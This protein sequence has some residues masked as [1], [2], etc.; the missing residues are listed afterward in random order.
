MQQMGF[1]PVL[2][3]VAL[4]AIAF[5]HDA[6]AC[7]CVEP[8]PVM[9]SPAKR[10]PA[11]LNS[12]V[13]VGLPTHK[14]AKLELRKVGGAAVV[15]TRS[16]STL[17][18]LA[19]VTLTPVQPL[20]PRAHY[21]VASIE[22]SKSPSTLVFGSFKTGET[23]DVTAPTLA[24]L[25]AATAYRISNSVGSMCQTSDPWLEVA[26]VSATDPGRAD[27]PLLFGVWL[28]DAAG[29]VSTR[30]PPLALLARDEGD[31]LRIGNASLCQPM[32]FPFP[33]QANVVL[34][35]AALDEAGNA[36]A[37]QTLRVALGAARPPKRAG[38]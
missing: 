19:Q 13:V 23:R 15:T 10:V 12:K 22:A 37:V 14:M 11:P 8:R 7:S 24:K 27:T 9:L 18:S 28:A 6:S 30:Q 16:E 2:A 3:P 31:L 29:R 38:P 34:G 26:S 1:R 20:A 5:A 33:N 17:G 21:Y 36:S 25:G 35:I 4:A 32:K